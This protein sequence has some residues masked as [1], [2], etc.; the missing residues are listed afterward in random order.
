MRNAFGSYLLVTRKLV[1]EIAL[2]RFWVLAWG[3][4]RNL[5]CE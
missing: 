5:D 4:P 1:V 3:R 2:V